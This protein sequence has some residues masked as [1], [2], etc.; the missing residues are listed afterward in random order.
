[1]IGVFQQEGL[2]YFDFIAKVLK[3]YLN[4]KAHNAGF[5]KVSADAYK[6]SRKQYEARIIIKELS[7]NNKFAYKIGLVDFDIYA[8]GM[9]FIFGMADPLKKTAL[10]STYRLTGEKINERVTKEV[11]H[12]VG[13]LLGLV[14]C[15]EP[16][17]V[18]Y[19]SNT[20]DD[21]DKKSVELCNNCRGRL[22]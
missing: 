8:R 4:L 16:H 2:N 9:N 17:C 19:F 22:E 20:I 15:A 21:T 14:H 13:H 10:V 1:M 18:M 11:I 7:Q 6:P 3:Q 12:E 5:F